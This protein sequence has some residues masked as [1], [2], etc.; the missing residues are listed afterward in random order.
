MTPRL[1]PPVGARDHTLGPLDA[2]FT[3]VEYGDFECPYCGRAFPVVK[4][5]QRRLGD[6]LLFV[7]R[8]FPLGEMHPHAESA[9]EMAEAAGTRGLF[10]EMHDLLFR[11]QQALTNHDLVGYATQLGIDPSWAEHELLSHTFA[12]R[13]HDDFMNGVRSGVNGTPT[14]FVNGFRFDGGAEELLAS[15]MQ[16]TIDA[17]L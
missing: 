16:A 10:W 14:F 2:P 12:G 11:N 13:V 3:L 1:T 6:Q 8:H 5:V 9:A 15:L 7:Y 17:P 4:S